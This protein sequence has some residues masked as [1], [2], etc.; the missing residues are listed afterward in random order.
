MFGETEIH[1]LGHQFAKIL[2]DQG[3]AFCQWVY[4]QCVQNGIGISKDLRK[5]VHCFKLSADQGN[6]DGQFY[7][8]LCL[9]YG[10]GI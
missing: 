10:N 4:G 6:S 9:Q 5:A 2:A 1:R 7:Y 8:G 3:N